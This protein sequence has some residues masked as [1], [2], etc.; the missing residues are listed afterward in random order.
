MASSLGSSGTIT[1]DKGQARDV[2]PV[3][4]KGKR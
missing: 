4:K 2:A 1:P 3:R